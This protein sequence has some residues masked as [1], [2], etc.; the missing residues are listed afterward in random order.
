MREN[1]RWVPLLI[2]QNWGKIFRRWKS[3]H[4][5][6]YRK[7]YGTSWW[8]L[9]LNLSRSKLYFRFRAESHAVKY[10]RFCC[11]VLFFSLGHFCSPPRPFFR[12]NEL[13]KVRKR[14]SHSSLS[15]QAIIL[16]F[17]GRNVGFVM[18]VFFGCYGRPLL[19][20]L[21]Q[22]WGVRSQKNSN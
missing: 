20:S 3:G 6:G 22:V 8:L 13:K 11:L 16:E 4:L 15:S 17:F 2:A 18:L 7:L 21:G 1:G 12:L 14:C 9:R 5:L 10:Y 19:P